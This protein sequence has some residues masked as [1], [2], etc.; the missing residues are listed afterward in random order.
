MAARD[1]AGESARLMRE[2]LAHADGLH[3]LAR[4]LTRDGARADDL[5]Q[6]T[7]ARALGAAGQFRPGTN[8]RAWLYRILRNTFIDLQRHEH[9][10]RTDGGLDTV[11]DGEGAP[12]SPDGRSLD[13]ERAVTAREIEVALGT[14]T[15]D[16]RMAV[17]L[18]LE[19]WTESEI[20]ECLGC[21]VGTVKSRLFRAREALR[22]R[23]REHGQ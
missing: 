19:G 15:E 17:L 8:L 7:Y 3:N 9:R 21:A 16:A 23:L 6:E 5:V 2:A 10:A 22:E 12:P 4:H 11:A 18:D 1:T 14:L 20:A 13:Q